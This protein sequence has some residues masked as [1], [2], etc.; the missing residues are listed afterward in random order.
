[1]GCKESDKKGEGKG[2]ISCHSNIANYVLSQGGS[3]THYQWRGLDKEGLCEVGRGFYML[4]AG[5]R[6]LHHR[7]EGL[8]CQ[9]SSATHCDLGE[10]VQALCHKAVSRLCSFLLPL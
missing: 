6:Q 2:C 10:A 8:A 9:L 4:L 3:G 7:M 1:M 5:L